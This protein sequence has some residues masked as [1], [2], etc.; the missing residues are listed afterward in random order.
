MD[1]TGFG[2]KPFNYCQ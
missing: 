1:L 2:N